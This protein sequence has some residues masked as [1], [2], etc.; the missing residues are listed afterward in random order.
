MVSAQ[1]RCFSEANPELSLW[2]RAGVEALGTLLLVLAGCGAGIAASRLFA[3][4]PGLVLPVVALALA[5]ALVALIVAFGS[6]S[7]GHFN[8]LITMLQWLAGERPG[9]CTAA[10][11]AAQLAG[12]ALGGLIAASLWQ[13]VTIDERGLGW[14]GAASELVAT[15]GLMLVV[16]GCARGRRVETGPFAVGAWLVAGIFATPTTSYANPAVLLGAL[17]TAGPLSLS[18]GSALPY[19]VGEAAGAMIALVVVWVLFPR[20]EAAA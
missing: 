20:P 17:V 12:G 8:P 15:A 1:A 3:A 18:V 6:V 9:S 13:T 10:Y 19:V 4:T 2:R 5:G 14:G 7:G 16:F 11:V